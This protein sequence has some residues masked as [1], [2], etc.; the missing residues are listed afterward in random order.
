MIPTK[1]YAHS[2]TFRTPLI[3]IF[4]ILS[5][6]INLYDL[7]QMDTFIKEIR[8][9]S[10]KETDNNLIRKVCNNLMP[11]SEH[12]KLSYYE[13]APIQVRIHHLYLYSN[14]PLI[15]SPN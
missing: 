8:A 12:Q 15:S 9:V 14:L 13:N 5:S 1:L 10:S 6:I 3:S 7:K 2:D 4:S 11:H